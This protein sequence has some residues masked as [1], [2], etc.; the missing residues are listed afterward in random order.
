M[1][2]GLSKGAELALLAVAMA[3]PFT[4]T[5][6]QFSASSAFFSARKAGHLAVDPPLLRHG[7]CRRRLLHGG[8]RGLPR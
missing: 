6:A 7:R 1:V 4:F 3:K 5:L 2:E 8:G